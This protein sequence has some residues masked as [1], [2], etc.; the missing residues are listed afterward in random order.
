ME[1]IESKLKTL[2]K[3]FDDS[4][5]VFVRIDQSDASEKTLEN[6]IALVRKYDFKII[7]AD[8]PLIAP[9]PPPAAKQTSKGGPNA[10]NIQSTYNPSFLEYIIEM[11]NENATFYLDDE[12]ISAKEAKAIATNHNGKRT[13]MT[14]QKDADGNYLV[15][16]SSAEKK[17][18]YAR[19]I[20]LR[21]LNENSYLIDGIKA[22]KE[23]FVDVFNQLHQD[24]TPE[25][26][27]NYMNIHVKSYSRY[28][29]SKRSCR[30]Q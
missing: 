11:E 2:S 25:Q 1:S 4:N 28:T 12:K 26:R 22:T 10:G 7:Q 24:I 29:N 18:I 16:L 20:E 14:T 9:P 6:V 3:S 17:K 19:S 21:V 13:N 15:K 23:T 27:K 30:I 5:S 8:A